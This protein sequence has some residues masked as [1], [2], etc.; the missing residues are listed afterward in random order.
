MKQYELI[1]KELQSALLVWLSLPALV[2]VGV[3]LFVPLMF[4]AYSGFWHAGFSLAHY[5]NFL[6][7]LHLRVI[8]RSI[9]FAGTA[10]V[11]AIGIAYPVAY[12]LAYINVRYKTLLLFLLTL[13]FWTNLIVQVYAW[14]FVLE[15]SGLL[16][17]FLLYFGL[18]NEPIQFAYNIPA[19]ILLMVYC[20]LPFS[21]IPLYTV[22][23]KIDATL[24]EASM[25]LGAT[26]WQTFWRVTW[27]LSLSGVQTGFLLVFVPA[28]GDFVIPSLVG[29]SRYLTVGS[30]ISY[31]FVTAQDSASGAIF[32]VI[33]AA[34]LLATVLV[35]Q[36]LLRFLAGQRKV[37]HVL[38]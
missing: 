24:I 4:M 23:H 11:I 17:N 38:Q 25:D 1:K 12:F 5:S 13:P 31:Y 27:P 6:D 18:I 8:G 29:G 9:F 30:L 37:R 14:F 35:I 20:Y 22:L 32:T 28:F 10:S 15:R 16:N 26:R 2:W 3:L 7:E 36:L 33:C 21:I 34:I 19:I